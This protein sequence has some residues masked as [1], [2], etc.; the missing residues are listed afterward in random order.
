MATRRRLGLVL[1]VGIVVSVIAACGAPIA[2]PTPTQ[3]SLSESTATPTT[4]LTVAATDTASPPTAASPTSVQGLTPAATPTTTSTG[5]PTRTPT[6]PPTE[7]P[8]ATPTPAMSDTPAPSPT[9]TRASSPTEDESTPAFRGE[10]LLE[11]NF[12]DEIAD[13]W[14]VQG[15]AW[16]IR[17]REYDQSNSEDPAW[18]YG[19]AVVVADY[20][21][22]AGLK[23]MPEEY[24]GDAMR[25]VGLAVRMADT[26]NFCMAALEW[27]KNRLA[28]Y[29]VINGNWQQALLA[30]RP[31]TL[32]PDTWYHLRVTLSGP[33]MRTYVD[34]VL[35][36]EA[37]CDLRTEGSIGLYTDEGHFRVD[38]I[39]VET[40][41]TFTP[42]TVFPLADNFGDG[43]SDG[44][45][46]LNGAWRVADGA[47]EQSFAG[48][49]DVWAYLPNLSAADGRIEARVR[50]L[51]IESGDA[52]GPPDGAVGVALRMTGISFGY[53]GAIDVA[54]RQVRLWERVN[55]AWSIIASQPLTDNV[56]LSAWHTL[57]FE[58]IGTTLRLYLD[59]LLVIETTDTTHTEG[60][61]GVR[62]NR[63]HFAIDDVHI[64]EIAPPSP[65]PAVFVPPQLPFADDF[66]DGSADGWQLYGLGWSVIDGALDQALY[67]DGSEAASAWVEL[68]ARNYAVT[69]DVRLMP[70]DYGDE[71]GRWIG[72]LI[73]R[74]GSDSGYWAVIK[75]RDGAAQIHF[76]NGQSWDNTISAAAPVQMDLSGWNMLRFEAY[77]DQLRFRVNGD[78]IVSANDSTRGAGAFGIRILEGH[79]QIDNVY[80]EE[81]DR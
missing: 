47:L 71:H 62:T 54:A 15:G 60:Y 28:L 70:E 45:Q 64:E 4:S 12:D 80:V 69:A 25:Q 41:P 7:T 61:F 2:T 39:R 59:G 81:I 44:W 16:G 21:A 27:Q 20:S 57:T 74:Q 5:T 42:I 56:D 55:G 75:V 72:L 73:R 17:A 65:T 63:G 26:N 68:P 76:G 48:A 1:T 77:E 32:W 14:Q 29:Q 35:Q 22:E 36:L 34:G 43:D 9:G 58:A 19:P 37:T 52:L 8:T 40:A 53:W 38:N 66:D 23:L 31:F 18:S 33:A 6:V 46:K 24:A 67:A 50:A 10:V 11:E 30:S 51:P 78:L 13:G 3:S 49:G 79:F